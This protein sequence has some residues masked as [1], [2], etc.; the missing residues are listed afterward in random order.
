MIHTSDSSDE[1][2]DC[3]DCEDDIAAADATVDKEDGEVAE[4][5]SGFIWGGHRQLLWT[6]KYC[7]C[8]FIII[9]QRLLCRTSY[10]F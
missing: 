10:E 3:A 6:S 4:Y 1:S 7:S 8:F 2:D 9:Q 5:I